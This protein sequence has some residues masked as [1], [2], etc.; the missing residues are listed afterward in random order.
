MEIELTQNE[1]WR[2]N[3]SSKIC[4]VCGEKIEPWQSAYPMKL[5]AGKRIIYK[6]AHMCHIYKGV[7]YGEKEKSIS[8]NIS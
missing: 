8:S 6:F 5:K 1:R 3:H 7:Y 2:L 4:V